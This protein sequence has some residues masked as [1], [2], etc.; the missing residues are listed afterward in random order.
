MG[1]WAALASP[2]CGS[3]T[4]TGSAAT[5]QRVLEQ[6]AAAVFESTPGVDSELPG[7]LMTIDQLRARLQNPAQASQMFLLDTRPRDE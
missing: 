5:P 4:T 7:N 6:R 3:D 1:C 2:S